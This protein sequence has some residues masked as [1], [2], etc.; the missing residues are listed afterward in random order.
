MQLCCTVGVQYVVCTVACRYLP[1]I[2][3]HSARGAAERGAPRTARQG[4]KQGMKPGNSS[5]VLVLVPAEDT[6]KCTVSQI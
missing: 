2:S 1:A 3:I 5:V 4:M 6:L